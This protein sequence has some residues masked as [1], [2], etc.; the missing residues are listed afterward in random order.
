MAIDPQNDVG[1][2]RLQVAINT[3]IAGAMVTT[4]V[5]AIMELGVSPAYE[6]V[7]V[8]PCFVGAWHWAQGRLGLTALSVMAAGLTAPCWADIPVGPLSW[9]AGI[10]LTIAVTPLFRSPW[11]LAASG[12]PGRPRPP[13]FV[14]TAWLHG[15]HVELTATSL[16]RRLEFLA[17]GLALVLI[18][19]VSVFLLVM[20]IVGRW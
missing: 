13:L 14:S 3:V 17:N 19:C 8:L 11:E 4:M 6:R 18:A 9:F 1:F 12:L 15:L 10:S 16:V 7:V 20:K 5:I 2:L